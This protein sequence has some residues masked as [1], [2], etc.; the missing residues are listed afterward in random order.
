METPRPRL[1]DLQ[2][3]GLFLY[4][5]AD[6][7]RFAQDAVLL[8][9]FA[10]LTARDRAVDLGAGT[11]AL[12]VLCG[13]RT[14]A[15]FVCVEKEEALCALLRRTAAYNGLNLPVHC[16]DWA[17]APAALG[18]GTFTAALCNPPYYAA[19]TQSPDPAR[20]A[21]RGGRNALKGAVSAAAKLLQNGGRLYLCYPAERLTDALVLLRGTGLEPKRLRLAAENAGAAPYLALICAR[22]GGRPGMKTEPLLFLRDEQGRDSAELRKIYH[23]E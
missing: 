14:G 7:P 6:L 13:A 17:D 19:G 16:M 18:R 2:Y 1:D 20:A 5:R 4:Q 10:D 15:A 9:A 3:K 8:A 12:A 11:G 22:K 23:M 21:A